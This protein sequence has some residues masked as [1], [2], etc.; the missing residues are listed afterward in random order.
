LSLDDAP[1]RSNRPHSETRARSQI[2]AVRVTPDERERYAALAARTGR[3]LPDLM[4]LAVEVLLIDE[5][6]QEVR[7][8]TV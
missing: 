5:V 6:R 3:S 7:R 1:A 2:V 4:R 8:G